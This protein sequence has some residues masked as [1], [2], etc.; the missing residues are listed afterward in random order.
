MAVKRIRYQGNH[1]PH[2][3]QKHYYANG[4]WI[5]PGELRPSCYSDFVPCTYDERTIVAR[6]YKYVRTLLAQTN[7]S[8]SQQQRRSSCTAPNEWSDF[9]MIST[10]PSPTLCANSAAS[11][12]RSLYRPQ[13][14]DGL[15]RKS[16][17]TPTTT[18][19]TTTSPRSYIR[20]PPPAAF[21]RNT[22]APSPLPV[23]NPNKRPRSVSIQDSPS[24]ITKSVDAGTQYSPPLPPTTK[25]KLDGYKAKGKR[26]GTSV[27]PE[28]P[29]IP[30]EPPLAP[31]MSVKRS[32]VATSW[33]ESN[34]ASSTTLVK[35]TSATSSSSQGSSPK[36]ARPAK[37]AVKLMPAEYETCDVKDLVVLISKM[38]MELV[39]FNDEIPLKDGRLTRFHSRAPPGI[40]IK[41]YL[42]RLTTHATLSPPI[43]LSMVYYIDRLCAL[44]PAFTISSLT[45]HRFLITS[46]TVASKGL[47]DSFWTNNLY[48]RVGGV[49]LKELALLELEFLWRVEWRIV[50][51]PEV[52]VDYYRSLIERSDGY[53]IEGSSS[54]AAGSST[55]RS[56]SAHGSDDS[57]GDVRQDGVADHVKE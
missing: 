21:V 17:I 48:A 13:S 33:D 5:H 47:S 24:P 4:A 12:P 25:H 40:S 10:S 28:I 55:A 36:R 9:E 52:L 50:P 3:N 7:G 57:M 38:L 11:S 19:T 20:P 49:S 46:A 23:S 35:E 34:I 42:Q 18:T 39:R 6:L 44:Y 15:Y 56:S 22:T 26:R 2:H 14:H 31:Q 16:K 29:Q 41:D 37:S 1:A 30:P 8:I 27:S 51:K 32:G 43:L 45:V 54:S 53:R